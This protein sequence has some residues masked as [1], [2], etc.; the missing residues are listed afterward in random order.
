MNHLLREL[1]PI[2]DEAWS[3]IEVDAKSRLTAYLGARQVVDFRGPTG[4]TTSSVPLGR[5]T[6][7]SPACD[8]V[9][10]SQRVVLPLVELRAD[11][12]VS[13]GD[14]EDLDR[15]R[16]DVSFDDLDRAARQI[17]LA[18]NLAVFRGYA[19]GH[20]T[21]IAEASVHQ[22]VRADPD[23]AR[24]PA[25]VAKA[26]QVL[27]EAGIGGPFA[28]VAG[29]DLYTGIIETP[30]SGDLVLDHLRQ[31][32][33]GPVVWVAGLEGGIVLSLRGGDYVMECG[34]DLSIGYHSHSAAA[35]QFYLEETFA[36][37]VLEPQAAVAVAS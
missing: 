28:L 25:S 10:V 33:G 16:R 37:Q 13:R 17:A 11:F 9:A 12:E 30:E 14:L 21:G 4:W 34:Q 18:E 6:P 15:G 8:G 31:I 5:T 1:A 24:Y 29:S 22:P 23:V 2:S 27:L 32:L 26:L 3:A 7:L 36:F 35:V 19:P 20:F